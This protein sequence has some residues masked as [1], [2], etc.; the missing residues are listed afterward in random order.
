[1]NEGQVY[2]ALDTH[3]KPA[4][5]ITIKWEKYHGPG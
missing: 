1:M 3:E 2:K 5:W 4:K